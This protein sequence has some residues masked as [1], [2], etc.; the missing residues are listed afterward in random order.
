MKHMKPVA[1]L[2]GG[3]Q[4]TIG[5]ARPRDLTHIPEIELPPLASS[6]ATHRKRR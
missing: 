2:R 6:A 4:Y 1:A 5:R 3:P